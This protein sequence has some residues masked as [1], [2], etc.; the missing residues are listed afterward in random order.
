MYTLNVGLVIGST[1]LLDEVRSCLS[2]Q[3]VRVVLE[4]RELG[5]S[6]SF[7]EKLERVQPDVLIVGYLLVADELAT[8]VAQIKATAGNPAVVLVGNSADPEII[9]RGLRSGADEYVYPPVEADLSAA[10]DRIG[11]QRA[12][13]KAGTRPRGKVLAFMGAKGGCGTT[14]LA[15]HLAVELGRQTNLLVLLADFDID[16]GLVGFLMKAQSRYTLADALASAHRLDLSLWKALVSNGRPNLEVLMAPPASPTREIPDPRS[17]RYIVPFVR[18]TYDWSLLDL[19]RGIT[20]QMAGTLAEVDET[21]I[22]TTSD[23]PALHQA[24]QII[25]TML[26][27]GFGQH[28]LHVI[29][30]R[31][32]KR[33]EVSLEELDRMLGVPV[34]ATLPDDY[35]ALYEAYSNGTLLAPNSNL[36]RHFAR[37]AARMSG[38][39][40]KV[41][42]KG[43]GLF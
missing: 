17:F 37:V 12:K 41:A 38:I 10:L 19:G 27:G 1:D 33:M 8:A 2:A 35:G 36:G 14:T 21:Y 31:V 42:K 40:P 26:D 7:L 22:V 30:N 43:F 20:P 39:E 25:Q 9:L 29:L 23:I 11:T 13:T 3:P 28:H 32:P 24:K 4:Q 16:S 5:D 34:Y 6:S 15:C 18:G